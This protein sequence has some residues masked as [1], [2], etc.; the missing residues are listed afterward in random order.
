MGLPRAQHTDPLHERTPHTPPGCRAGGEQSVDDPHRGAVRHAA[1]LPRRGPLPGGQH[2][3]RWVPRPPP[4][5]EA[6][7]SNGAE[8]PRSRDVARSLGVRPPSTRPQASSTLTPPTARCRWR[9]RSWGS[10]SATCWRAWASWTRSATKRC[11]GGGAAVRWCCA[12]VLCCAAAGVPLR[13]AQRRGFARHRSSSD[14]RPRPPLD[15]APLVRR[16][17]TR[18]S[19]AS[20]RW[21]L[22]TGGRSG[23]G[24]GTGDALLG[25]PTGHDVAGVQH[26]RPLHLAAL[27]VP[28]HAHPCARLRRHPQPQGHG[29][30]GAHADAQG[31]AGGGAEPVRL[32][33]GGGGSCGPAVGGG[34]QGRAV[35]P[36][37]RTGPTCS[38]APALCC[39]A[40]SPP[41]AVP[42]VPRRRASRTCRRT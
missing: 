8:L 13:D 10:A 2:R 12:M 4:A 20:R 31:A 5:G 25:R 19:A 35:H 26:R 7:D 27:R 28:T 21:S 32:L 16:S 1:Q 33:A 42:L 37:R 14:A 15:P 40:P 39:A 3:E 11:G 9:W 18:S 30:D 22:C 17:P 23:L 6:A 41:V 36:P 29:Q 34:R 24:A 38:P